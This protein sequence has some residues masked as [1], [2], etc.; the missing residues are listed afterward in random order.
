M[1]QL[2]IGL[3]VVVV[4][5][6]IGLVLRRRQIIDVPTQPVFDAPAQLDRS[7]FPTSADAPWMVAVFT[8]ATCASCADVL[9][10]A[11]VLQS[12]Q[13]AVVDVEYTAD[14]D[15]HAKYHIDGVPILVIADRLGVV[16]RSFVGPVTATDLWAAVAEARA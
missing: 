8:S 12:T 2:L 10:K 1:A 14:R 13:V 6:A 16:R 9:R 15:L 11:R 5:V 3:L 4:A 7:D